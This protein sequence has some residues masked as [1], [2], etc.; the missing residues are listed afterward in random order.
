MGF[1]HKKKLTLKQ[2]LLVAAGIIGAVALYCVIDQ[3]IYNSRKPALEACARS[4]LQDIVKLNTYGSDS[5]SLSADTLAGKK[6]KEIMSICSKYYLSKKDNGFHSKGMKELV[7]K[8]KNNNAKLIYYKVSGVKVSSQKLPWKLHYDVKVIYKTDIQ[9]DGEADY[10]DGSVFSNVT[11]QE[12]S[13]QITDYC[14]LTLDMK[15]S[16]GMIKISQMS[17]TGSETKAGFDEILYGKSS[18]SKG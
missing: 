1:K 9:Y 14:L 10:Y 6:V 4:Y 12:G 5:Q 3:I 13:H 16:D 7:L 17:M 2:R 18:S 15:K 11:N 8:M